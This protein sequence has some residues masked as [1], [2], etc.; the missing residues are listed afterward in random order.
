MQQAWAVEEEAHLRHDRP[1]DQARWVVAG[2]PPRMLDPATEVLVLD[3][4]GASA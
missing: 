4:S 1:W 3:R 2:A